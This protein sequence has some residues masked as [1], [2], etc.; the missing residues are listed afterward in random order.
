MTKKHFYRLLA[1][2]VMLSA[3]SF[4]SF[5]SGITGSLT[6]FDVVNNTQH[7]TH[8][9]EI[10]LHGI[11]SSD[12]SFT[13]SAPH[14]RYG[15]PSLVDFNNAG[16]FGVKVRYESSWDAA[17]NQFLQET[18]IVTPGFVPNS[19]SCWSGGLGAGYSGSGCEHFGVSLRKQAS[20]TKYRWL[21]GDPLTGLLSAIDGDIALPAPLWQASPPAVAGDPPMVEAEIEIPNPEGRQ[22]GDAY[23]VKIYKTEVDHPVALDNLLLDDVALANEAVEIEWEMLQAKPGALL[24]LN[25]DVLGNGNEAVIRR[26]EFYSYNTAWGSTHFYDDNGSLVSYV[27]QFNGEVT[28]CVVDGCNAP[29]ADELGDYI[30]RQIAGVNLAAPVPLPPASWLML[31]GLFTFARNKRLTIG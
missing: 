15:S 16:D 30:G 13:F 1:G 20:A 17:L 26:Y 12:I 7:P 28:A 4:S 9:F 27:D 31:A 8:G 22:Y 3:S 25:Q 11:S 5:A 19:H 23:W 2:S 6:N 18:P 24:A 14:I 29:T 21:T 10:E